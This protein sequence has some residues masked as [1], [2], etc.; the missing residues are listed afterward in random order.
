MITACFF[1]NP[2]YSE[3]SFETDRGNR[4]PAVLGPAIVD[5]SVIVD[6]DE[7]EQA[8]LASTDS[9]STIVNTPESSQN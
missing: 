3:E 4:S 5:Q 8:E 2:A 6:Y 1:S 9:N 7:Q